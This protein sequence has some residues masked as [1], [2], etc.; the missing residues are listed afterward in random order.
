MHYSIRR[1][2]ACVSRT[3][4]FFCLL[5]LLHVVMNT[6]C[7]EAGKVS[8]VLVLHSY[9]QGLQWTDTIS[10]GIQSEFERYSKETEIHYEYLDTK[11][12]PGEAYFKSLVQFESLKT[13][14]ADINF[15]VII[16]SDNTAL[17]FI[18]DHGDTLYPHV[19]VVFCGVNNYHPGLLK[20]KTRI[21]GVVEDIDYHATL[22]LMKK[23]HPT[24]KRMLVVLDKTPTGLAIKKDLVHALVASADHFQIEYYQDFILDEVPHKIDSLGSNDIIYLLAFNR[25][26]ENN[27]ISYVDGIRM[28][29]GVSKV[30]IYGSWDFYYGNGIVGGMITSGFSQGQTAAILAKQI[31]SGIPADEIPIITKSPNRYQFDHAQMSRFGIKRSHLPSG[32]LIINE[33]PGLIDR[34]KREIVVSLGV[35]SAVL[36]ILIWRLMVHKQQ[37]RVLHKTN[38]ELDF[39]VAEQTAAL[40]KK[41]TLLE[42]EIREKLNVEKILIEKTDRLEQALHKVKT[43]NG[44]LPICSGCKKIRDDQGYWNQIESY[45]DDHSDATF[46]HGICPDCAA[47]LYPELFSE[48][49]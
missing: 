4:G 47:R 23:L 43:L 33:P 22:D 40:A 44:L 29:Q 39:R 49:Q 6:N 35:I 27:F 30:P 9:H 46:S 42:K 7:A 10:A 34:Y 16:A 41:N 45:I 48:D 14:L 21:T 11:R 18:V 3:I 15:E 1:K 5:V 36:L 13:K 38:V 31:L 17:R 28:I 25:D 19:P 24:R 37:R 8:N 32:S 2:G 12:N 20:G 26:R